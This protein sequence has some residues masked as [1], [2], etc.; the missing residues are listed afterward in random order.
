MKKKV[1]GSK[2]KTPGKLTAKDFGALITQVRGLIQSARYAAATTVNTLQVLTNFEIGRRI[3]EHEQKGEARAGYGELMMRTLADKLSVE[4]GR[5]FS[6]RNLD[7]MRRFYLEYASRIPR[8]VQKPSAPLLPIFLDFSRNCVFLVW[9]L[10]NF[11]GRFK[12]LELRIFM[13]QRGVSL[14]RKRGNPGIGDGETMSGFELPRK[15]SE[16]FS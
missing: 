11:H 2:S 16:C 9:E 6:K 7:Y 5:G 3:V 13:H 1:T 10:Q 8:M 14:L 15:H 4:F 12:L